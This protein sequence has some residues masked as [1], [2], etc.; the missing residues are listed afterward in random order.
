MQQI[1]QKIQ[2]FHNLCLICLVLCLICLALT[3]FFFVRF[4]IWNIFHIRTGLSEKKA[5]KR[6][7]ERNAGTGQRR[8]GQVR[9]ISGSRQILK[10]EPVVPETGVLSENTAAEAVTAGMKTELYED[11]ETEL[12][13]TDTREYSSQRAQDQVDQSYGKFLLE[14]GVMLIHTEEKIGKTKTPLM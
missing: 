14:S 6:M 1:Q 7:E 4:D 9:G 12:L 5:V 11:V 8:W 10:E 2:L 13:K 3:I